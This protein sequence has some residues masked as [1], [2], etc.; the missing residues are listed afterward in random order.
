MFG[1]VFNA[2]T[3]LVGELAEVDLPGVAGY[4]QHEDVGTRAKDA[5][6]AAGNDDAAHVGVLKADAVERVMQLNVHPQ[7]VA[8]ELELVARTNPAVLRNVEGQPRNGALD[9]QGP[10]AVLRGVSAVVNAFGSVGEVCHEV[11][12]EN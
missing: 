11:S 5:V 1:G 10:V 9:R 7:V 2:V 6:L 8:V 4:P 3:R 12:V